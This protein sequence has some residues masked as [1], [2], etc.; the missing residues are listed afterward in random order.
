MNYL[1]EIKAF[2][3]LVQIK[4][5]STGQIALWY[6]LMYINNKCAWIEWFTV[7]NITLELNC[8]LSKSGIYKA[9]NVLKQH[10]ILDFK[11]NGT[12]A[13]SY[14][15]ISLEKSS[16][17]SNRVGVK[18][19]STIQDS[20]RDSNLVGNQDSNRVGS[21]DS[22]LV[23]NPLNKLNETKQK[24]SASTQKDVKD[25][26]V[27][28][29]F[30]NAWSLYPSKK[31]KGQISNTKKKELYK[32]GEELERCI[33]RYVKYVENERSKGFKDLKYQNGSTFFN[34]GYVDYLDSNG[35]NDVNKPTAKPPLKLV[36]RDS[37]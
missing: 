29:F 34:S 36:I 1:T 30:E 18:E 22:N 23:G 21:Q 11:P 14:K 20:N 3:D 24:N 32:L 13:T 6:S 8:G 28:V 4:Q 5:L 19:S 17:S 16:Q 25:N 27:E 26:L 37:Y 31:G 9:R 7:P 12:K 33:S 35:F 2:H 10:N 15:L